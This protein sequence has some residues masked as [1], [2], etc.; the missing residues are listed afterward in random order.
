MKNNFGAL[1]GHKLTGHVSNPS[2]GLK[3]LIGV[4]SAPQV[5]SAPVAI[6]AMKPGKGK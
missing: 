1:K 3:P 4:K 6:K 5:S 2:K